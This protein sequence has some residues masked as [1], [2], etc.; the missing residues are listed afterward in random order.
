MTGSEA[1]VMSR[2][3]VTFSLRKHI[4]AY[5][6][7]GSIVMDDCMARSSFVNNSP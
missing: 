6:D 3:L 1:R 4:D 5:T 2:V 7:D